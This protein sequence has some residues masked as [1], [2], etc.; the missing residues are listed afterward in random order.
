MKRRSKHKQN[1]RPSKKVTTVAPTTTLPV[2]ADPRKTAFC[3]N[4]FDPKSP[5][6]AR[7]TAS[8]IAAGFAPSTAE[9]LWGNKPK[10]LT[11]L[12]E[13]E[14]ERHS[15]MLMKAE[16]NLEE[17]LDLPSKV[18]AMGPFGPLFEK[19]GKKVKGQTQK[20]RPVMVYSQGLIKIREQ[21]SEFVAESIGRKDYA[22]D[23]P[24]GNQTL[25]L[26]VTGETAKRYGI[27]THTIPGKDSA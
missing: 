22:A 7:M 21:A 8:A 4:Y 10:W 11:E 17:H 20:K 13:R 6:F 15:R 16:R 24:Q 26:M 25:V 12:M 19:L 1:R 18:Q 3:V 5:T 14:R 2:A 9:N 27:G 23:V